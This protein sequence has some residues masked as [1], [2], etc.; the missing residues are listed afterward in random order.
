MEGCCY[1]WLVAAGAGETSRPAPL[2]AA[3]TAAT[4]SLSQAIGTE[5]C[6]Y[7]SEITKKKTLNTTQRKV[8]YLCRALLVQQ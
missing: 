8:L 3:Q 1:L 5:K 7:V 4:D 2:Q 6:A